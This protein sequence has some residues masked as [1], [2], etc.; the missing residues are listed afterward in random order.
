MS[1]KQEEK[2]AKQLKLAEAEIK[3]LVENTQKACGKESIR[4][5]ILSG[6]IEK[7]P[8]TPTRCLSLDHALGIGGYPKGRICEFFGPEGCGKT[9]MAATAVAEEQ[10]TGGVAAY[11]DAEHAVDPKYFKNI[12]VNLDNLLFSQPDTAEQA[13]E[14]CDQLV[15]SNKLD[16][17]VV[18]SVAALVP[19]AELEGEMGAQHVGL[20]ARLMGQAM[21]KLKGN[22]SKTHTCVIFINQ[23][24]EKIGM[25]MPGSSNEVTPGG[26]ALKF[27]ASIRMDIRRIG[28]VQDKAGTKIG[29]LT[30]VKVIKNKLA[31][32]FRETTFHIIYGKGIEKM[33]NILDT[34]VKLGIV[35]RT[36]S[37]YGFESNRMGMSRDA[38][39][40][41]MSSVRLGSNETDPLYGDKIE[42]LT[43]EK[44]FSDMI[45]VK[46]TEEDEENE[47]IEGGANE[48][49]NVTPTAVEVI[50][51]D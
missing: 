16:I 23:I 44:L 20:Q 15:R 22:V 46:D 5:G 51:E 33:G 24:R 45:I 49:I 13:L 2:E 41:F 18:D 35:E 37:S 39:I 29:N 28:A 19:K 10:K 21:R 40:E 25:N 26:R 30:K 8:V 31:P 43:R 4:R 34:A 12:G 9:T 48:V 47:N 7:W 1:K 6:E 27:Y 38:A 50:K 11:I 17:I 32:P 3:E 14:I 36:G 42:K